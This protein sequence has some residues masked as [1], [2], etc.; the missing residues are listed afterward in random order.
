MTS[1]ENKTLIRRVFDEALNGGNLSVVDELFAP[2]FVDN[3]TPEQVS[4]P[5]GVKDY[6]HAVRAVFPDMHLSIDDLIAEGD[7]VVVRTTWRGTHTGPY[8]GII[9]TGKPVI[10]TMIQI[11]RIANGRIQEEWNEGEGLIEGGA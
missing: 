3:S 6:F 2:D 8:E 11:F 5:V 7:K 10:R 9:P 4:G 1:E